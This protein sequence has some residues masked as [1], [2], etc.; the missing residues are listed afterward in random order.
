MYFT[1][2][3]RLTGAGKVLLIMLAE[4][5]LPVFMQVAYTLVSWAFGIQVQ[6]PESLLTAWA[7]YEKL[8]PQHTGNQGKCGDDRKEDQQHLHCH[9][10]SSTHV[11]V[12]RS[13]LL[14]VC[15]DGAQPKVE[16]YHHLCKKENLEKLN[17]Y[18]LQIYK[19]RFALVALFHV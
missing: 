14:S 7:S 8:F 12:E 11:G 15:K 3:N 6:F 1:E 16:R 9:Q 18:F 5:I 2:I 4:L 17:A 10:I 19:K 13:Y